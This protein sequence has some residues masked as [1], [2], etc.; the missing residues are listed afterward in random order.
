MMGKLEHYNADLYNVDSNMTRSPYAPKY[1]SIKS[2]NV[3]KC[4]QT[5]SVY[6][7][8]AVKCILPVYFLAKFDT[9]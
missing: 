3:R 5:I 8:L 7:M 4:Y 1:K 9:S 6:T 2:L